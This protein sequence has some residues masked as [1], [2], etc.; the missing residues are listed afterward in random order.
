MRTI[1]ISVAFAVA[2]G[3]GL[4]SLQSDRGSAEPLSRGTGRP[5]LVELYQSQ[6]CSSCPPANAN[7]NAIADRPDVIALSF[8]VT[9]WDYLGWR[10]SFAKQQ[11][12]QRQWDYARYNHLPNV[13]TPQVWINGRTTI[14][15]N[16]RSQLETAI[17]VANDP[18][19]A[20][21]INAGKISVGAGRAPA[22]GA[23]VWMARFD[24]RTIAVPI[25]AGENGGRTL[26]HRNIVRQLVKI[27]HWSGSGATFDLPG[28]Q[29][30]LSTTV[31]L[32]AGTG[33]PVIAAA[34]S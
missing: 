27:G 31:F 19:P 15:G 14:V 30:G 11:F 26:P 5:V 33:G 25:R 8:A 2:A 16:N 3:G 13:A 12:T 24:P 32:Q 22:S 23:D 6:G 7:I 10:D 34:R 28:G 4:F 20:L 21:S 1:V 17:R 29:Q 18:G 9:Y